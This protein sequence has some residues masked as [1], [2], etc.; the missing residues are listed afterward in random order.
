VY[1]QEEKKHQQQ[2]RLT[3]EKYSTCVKVDKV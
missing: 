1:N 3:A 2:H